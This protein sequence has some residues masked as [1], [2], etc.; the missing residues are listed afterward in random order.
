MH[1]AS[2][3]FLASHLKKS[4]LRSMT[5]KHHVHQIPVTLDH[6]TSMLISSG[7]MIIK[8]EL[9]YSPGGPGG[10]IPKV[11]IM[12]SLRF[13]IW[14][15]LSVSLSWCQAQNKTSID[16]FDIRLSHLKEWLSNLSMPKNHLESSL[17]HW[18]W[19]PLQRYQSSMSGVEPTNRHI[20]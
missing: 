12:F 13:W 4:A 11:D 2:V 10:W 17:K 14:A 16:V 15:S 9:N 6:K 3:L 20:H 19:A 18:F 8:K 1:Q 7:I 5:K